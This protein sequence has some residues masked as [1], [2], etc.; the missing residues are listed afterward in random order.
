MRPACVS[1]DG[2]HVLLAVAQLAADVDAEANV[3]VFCSADAL[4][5]EPDVAD[6]HDAAYFQH[7]TAATP[8]A[9]GRECAAIPAFAH[10][11]EAARRETALDVGSLITVVGVLV[12]SGSYP[13]LADLEVVGQPYTLPLTTALIGLRG[14]QLGTGEL[15]VDKVH[16]VTLRTSRQGY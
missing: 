3:A 10:L 4:T 5:I 12:S 16:R 1:Q 14:R 11:L 6:E 7:D 13:R 9:V 8:T 15:P 2:E